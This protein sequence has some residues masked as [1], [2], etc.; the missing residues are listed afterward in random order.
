MN[1]SEK[2]KTLR[3]ENNLT[4]EE[5]AEQIFV[6]RTLISKY[7]SG[8][9]CPTEENIAKL[10]SFF[11]IDESELIF[12]ND[13]IEPEANKRKHK[14]NIWTFFNSLIILICFL[15]ILITALPIFPK[16]EYSGYS[17]SR[18]G[19]PCYPIL[20]YQYHNGYNLTLS[21][22][23]PILIFALISAIINI[24]LSLFSI[25]KK[26]NKA[27]RIANYVLFILNIFL[28]FFSFIFIFFY[29]E[30]ANKVY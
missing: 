29:C 30:G 2:L 25:I 13:E 10:A 14:F 26:D 11:N 7:E 24:A 9:V 22:S 28:F 27:L 12:L 5:L 6:S 23:N 16:N 17:C 8:A 19:T 3:K 1:F 4:Q 18:D 20:R 15:F 21:N